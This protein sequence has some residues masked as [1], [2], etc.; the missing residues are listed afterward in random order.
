[1]VCVF[2]ACEV[3][4]TPSWSLPGTRPQSQ[5]SCWR[6]ESCPPLTTMRRSSRFF[7]LRLWASPSRSGKTPARPGSRP[8]PTQ[9]RRPPLARL[10]G[11]RSSSACWR[12]PRPCGA[13][14]G[15]PVGAAGGRPG[16]RGFSAPA[17]HS[18]SRPRC[19]GGVRS[20]NQMSWFLRTMLM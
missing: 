17:L 8:P 6:Q 10:S 15:S 12:P 20:L 2:S 7:W 9:C 16:R 11:S 4:S 3:G 13:A 18:A 1:T 19:L 5:T 14:A